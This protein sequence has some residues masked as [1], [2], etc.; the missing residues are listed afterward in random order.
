M[1]HRV[2]TS[3]DSLR[4]LRCLECGSLADV[5]A[6]GWR[7]YLGGGFEGEPLEVGIYCPECAAR[8]FDGPGDL[9]IDDD[10]LGELEIERRRREQ[11]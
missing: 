6:H 1:S 2:E 4:H 8:E 3:G 7:G 10:L 11:P 5:H 9:E